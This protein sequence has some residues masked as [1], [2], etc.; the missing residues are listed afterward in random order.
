VAAGSSFATGDNDSQ[1]LIRLSLSNA[2][3]VV[4][5][6]IAQ[7]RNGTDCLFWGEVYSG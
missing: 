6:E 1:D 5:F 3:N 7:A 4:D 2:T